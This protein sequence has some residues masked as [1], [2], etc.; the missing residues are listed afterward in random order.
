MNIIVM[1]MKKSDEDDK[2]YKKQ[3]WRTP[4]IN[5]SNKYPSFILETSSKKVSNEYNYLYYR[6][7]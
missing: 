4:R 2:D 1:V 7:E 5:A 3:I 6:N